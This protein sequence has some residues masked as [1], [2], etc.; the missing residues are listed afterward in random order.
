MNVFEG[1]DDNPM[2][3]LFFDINRDGILDAL[4]SERWDRSYGGFHGNDW[5]LYQ[6]KNGE[7]QQNPLKEINGDNY[8][9][10]NEVFAKVDDFYCLTRDGQKPKLVFV[11]SA[12]RKETDGIMFYNEACEVT[13]D[14][15]GYLKTIPIPELSGT[16][17]APYPEDDDS[18]GTL[19]VGDEYKALTKLLVP[20]SVESFYPQEK[21]EGENA[22]PVATAD[23]GIGQ[24][25]SPPNREEKSE[26]RNGESE[27]TTQK[28]I[29]RLWLYVGIVLCVFCTVFF[30]LRKRFSKN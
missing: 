20:L 2:D 1:P 9:R 25:A 12:S 14:S 18:I 29:H 24:H 11:F 7:W 3:V 26:I 28:S 4:V 27:T 23:A 5:C 17:L 30:F 15:D 19:D 13:I 21:N 10:S 22:Q 16:V 6:F 8:D